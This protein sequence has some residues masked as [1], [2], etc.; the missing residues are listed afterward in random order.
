MITANESL[1]IRDFMDL[2]YERNVMRFE[3]VIDHERRTLNRTNK[4]TA[5]SILVKPNTGKDQCI[6]F[7]QN[8][9]Q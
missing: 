9:A 1:I 3:I 5:R 7:P 2:I 4:S 8:N 6:D